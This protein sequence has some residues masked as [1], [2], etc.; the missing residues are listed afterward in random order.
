ME[1]KIT[2]TDLMEMR[3]CV[4]FDDEI[5]EQTMADTIESIE[6]SIED[7]MDGIQRA[8]LNLL[9]KAEML[10]KEIERLEA[11][12]KALENRADWLKG[13]I[14]KAMIAMNKADV[15]TLLYSFKIQKNPHTVE[16]TGNVP[17]KF[18]IKQDPKL[19]K[20]AL[21][22]YLKENGDTKYARLTQTE[23]LRIR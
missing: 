12:K 3:N 15:K 19:D 17:K 20:K 9:G 4:L 21:L 7:K 18:Y 14:E 5:D 2:L 22:A 23:S 10:D 8:R 6:A 11:K 1:T 13:Y 16:V